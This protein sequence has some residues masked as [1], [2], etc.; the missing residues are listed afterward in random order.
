M[1]LSYIVWTACS[2]VNDKTGSEAA[3]VVVIICLFIFYLGYD[4]SFTPL[5]MS[6]PTEIFPYSIR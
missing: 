1:L 3:G 4:C 6:Y 2:A 5:L